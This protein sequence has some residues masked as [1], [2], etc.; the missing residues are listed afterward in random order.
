VIQFCL[1][2]TRSRTTPRPHQP[3]ALHAHQTKALQTH[4][5]PLGLSLNHIVLGEVCSDI[6]NVLDC[7]QDCRLTPQTNTSLFSI[8][9]LHSHASREISHKVTHPKIVHNQALLTVEF[10]SFGLP[11]R[12]YILLI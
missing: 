4:Q 11:K 6:Y 12:R 10:L 5:L 1:V 3:R 7:F 8:F 9:C 2:A